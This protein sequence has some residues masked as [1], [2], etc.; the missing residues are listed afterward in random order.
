MAA[1]EF[2]PIDHAR[3]PREEGWEEETEEVIEH[4]RNRS[5]LRIGQ[6]LIN[7]VS[8]DLEH[9]PPSEPEKDVTDMTDEEAEEYVQQLKNHRHREKAKIEQKLWGIEA[10]RL[11]KLL[12]KFQDIEDE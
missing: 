4:I 3:P 7:A 5:D 6:L 8:R 9:E 1:E 10:D 12:D 11:L 2:N